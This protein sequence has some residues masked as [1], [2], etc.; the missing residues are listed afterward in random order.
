MYN[1]VDV[2]ENA[3][4]NYISLNMYNVV[5]VA[6]MRCHERSVFTEVVKGVAFILCLCFA[7]PSSQF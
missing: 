4:Q 1:A 3:K 5:D 7:T 2:A 6:G